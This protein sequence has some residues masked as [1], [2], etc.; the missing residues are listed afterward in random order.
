VEINTNLSSTTEQIN[1]QTT[2]WIATA[3][4]NP[5]EHS[6]KVNLNGAEAIESNAMF[7]ATLTDMSGKV[8]TTQTLSKEALTEEQF[9]QDLAPGMYMLTLRQAEEMRV[10]RV[11]K[12]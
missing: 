5:F 3:T 8:Y 2:T 9:G 11:V 4:S 1:T 7:T 6:F 12:R 10:L